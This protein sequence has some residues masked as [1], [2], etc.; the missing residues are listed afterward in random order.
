MSKTRRKITPI[1]PKTCVFEIPQLYQETI[2]KKPFL[3][4]DFF[5]KRAK[6]RVI[7]YATAQQLKLLF[8]SDIIFMD[9]TFSVAPD[10]FEQVFLIHAQHFGQS[11]SIICN[12]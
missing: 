5:L 6:E 2:S 12:E 4:M 11:K 1:I 7:V 3:L 10:G 9:G 8:S